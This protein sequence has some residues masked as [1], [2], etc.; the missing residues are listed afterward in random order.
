MP[1][2][3]HRIVLKLPDL[4]HE[5]WWLYTIRYTMKDCVQPAFWSL[6]FRTIICEIYTLKSRWLKTEM[7]NQF[8]QAAA[9]CQPPLGRK[10]R[11]KSSIL[12]GERP[13]NFCVKTTRR[14]S[15]LRFHMPS[16][17][18]KTGRFRSIPCRKAQRSL[19]HSCSIARCI[20]GIY[21]S[22]WLPVWN[23]VAHEV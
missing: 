11:R 21:H 2:Y 23:R 12:H 22:R 9:S 1:V 18:S 19:H 15:N 13:S 5:S 14:N 7:L 8:S 16:C 6:L 3:A 17:S 10:C 20:F 4:H